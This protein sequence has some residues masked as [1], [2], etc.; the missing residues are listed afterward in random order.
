[1]R[2]LEKLSNIRGFLYN[3]LFIFSRT[4]L[5]FYYCCSLRSTGESTAGVTSS[6]I[7]EIILLST[8]VSFSFLFSSFVFGLISSFVFNLIFYLHFQF[9]SSTPVST[10]HSIALPFWSIFNRLILMI[11]PRNYYFL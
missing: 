9:Y 11:N 2:F 10:E 4:R 1:M 6:F 7:L 8:L 5:D 3:F